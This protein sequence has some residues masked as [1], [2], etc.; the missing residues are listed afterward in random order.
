MIELDTAGSGASHS[1]M[2]TAEQR[3]RY[4]KARREKRNAA[5]QEKRRAFIESVAARIEKRC[6][7]CLVVKPLSDY[8][9]DKK[10]ADKRQSRCKVC[11]RAFS[12]KWCQ[13][14]KARHKELNRLRYSAKATEIR[15]YHREH[16]LKNLDAE[17]ERA[18]SFMR[19]KRATRSQDERQKELDYK[20]QS[21]LENIEKIRVYKAKYKKENPWQNRAQNM[22]RKAAKLHRTPSWVDREAVNQ[23]Y[24]DCPAG[25]TVD[26]IIPLQGKTVSGLHVPWNLQYLTA[27]E[28]SR[29]GNKCELS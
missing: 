19:S 16:R 23:I 21:Y 8:C 22:R 7:A 4:N 26:H 2:R 5:A 14:N 27:S 18:R 6:V 17:R 11:T 9:N 13:E 3:D 24:K 12:R 29:K 28:N 20:K 15:Q 10:A 25:L 1:S